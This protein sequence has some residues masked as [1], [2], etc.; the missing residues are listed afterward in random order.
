MPVKRISESRGPEIV[1]NLLSRTGSYSWGSLT[2][3]AAG[4]H[5]REISSAPYLCFMTGRSPI[6]YVPG[7]NRDSVSNLIGTGRNLLNRGVLMLWR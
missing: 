7:W 4:C 3:A 6:F 5:I 1:K 2:V